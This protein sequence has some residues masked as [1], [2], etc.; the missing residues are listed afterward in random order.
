MPRNPGSRNAARGREHV[1]LG[2]DIH[3]DE[4]IGTF[5][6]YLSPVDYQFMIRPVEVGGV[7]AR[8]EVSEVLG[9]PLCVGE[10]REVLD[11]VWQRLESREQ[12]HVV[13]LNAEMILAAQRQPEAQDALHQ[14]DLYIS[15]GVGLTW[16]ARMLR[17]NSVHRYPGID[18]A[19]D[20]MERLAGKRGSVFL[21][22]SEEGVADEAGR[23]LQARLPGL[24]I[25]GTACGFFS[26][27]EEEAVVAN[28]AEL[29]PDLLLVGMGCPKQEQFIADHRHQLE[30]AVMV[31]V[32]GAL[33]VFAGRRTRAP[34]WMRG[35]G[36]E[37]AFRSMQDMSRFKR[38]GLL[39][40]FILMVLQQAMRRAA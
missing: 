10:P 36:L 14:G 33:E 27:H 40:R 16:A 28:I 8:I 31:G 13:T 12:T 5:N 25:A 19:F 26:D 17:K 30:T 35:T 21:L 2:P 29:K 37:W 23:R 15:D 24:V 39:P 6:N 22:G 1:Q 9:Y 32:G 18:L 34:Q 20:T 7:S 11:M 4:V 38:L 3:P